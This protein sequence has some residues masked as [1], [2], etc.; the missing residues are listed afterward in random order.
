MTRDMFIVAKITVEIANNISKLETLRANENNDFGLALLA[1]EH[2]DLTELERIT[3]QVLE[4]IERII[5][6]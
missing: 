6:Q 5:T 4:N 2:S 3:S 1:L